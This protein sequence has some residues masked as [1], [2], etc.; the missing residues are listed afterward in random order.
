MQGRGTLTPVE[1][2][3]ADGAADFSLSVADLGATR[4][5]LDSL[6]SLRRG[7]PEPARNAAAPNSFPAKLLV[8]VGIAVAAAAARRAGRVDQAL[9]LVDAKGLGV[10]PGELRG[11][12][13][14]AP[15]RSVWR[16]P[17]PYRGLMILQI[18]RNRDA[19][20]APGGGV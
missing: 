8:D 3:G 1:D 17:Q 7:G 14:E 18:V 5:V 20:L 11:E 2:R 16:G 4:L 13:V 15:V 19:R 12:G 9:A 6:T 10:Q